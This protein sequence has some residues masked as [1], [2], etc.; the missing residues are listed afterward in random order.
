MKYIFYW[1]SLGSDKFIHDRD[2]AWLEK[3]DGKFDS[4]VLS[5]NSPF[6]LSCISYDVSSEGLVL[7]QM[8]F[9]RCYFSICLKVILIEY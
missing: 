3:S 6:C 7:N 2:M 9:P 4:L 1:I 8:I 5:N